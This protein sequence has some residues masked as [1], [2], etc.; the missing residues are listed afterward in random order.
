MVRMP[1]PV[2]SFFVWSNWNGFYRYLNTRL[3]RTLTGKD[4]LVELYISAIVGA[5]V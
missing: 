3:P 4:V 2:Q 5:L 1:G